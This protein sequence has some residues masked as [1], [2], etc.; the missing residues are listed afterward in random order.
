MCPVWMWRS[1]RLFLHPMCYIMQ[2][3][4]EGLSQWSQNTQLQAHTSF[5]FSYLQAPQ[6]LRLRN[7]T[8]TYET[9]CINARSLY[10]R[11]RKGH[12]GNPGTHEVM[13]RSWAEMEIILRTTR[14]CENLKVTRKYTYNIKSKSEQLTPLAG[15]IPT[16]GPCWPDGQIVRRTWAHLW[17]SHYLQ[18]KCPRCFNST[19]RLT[20]F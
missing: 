9:D 8:C 20:F 19:E 15:R 2:H 3:L 17:V 5:K 10:M 16:T 6:S 4:K 11:R 1:K 7:K 18:H 12:E 14:T 13:E